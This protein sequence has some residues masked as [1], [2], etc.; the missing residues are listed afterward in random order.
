MDIDLNK[1][2]NDGVIKINCM[3]RKNKKTEKKQNFR[4]EF[5][6]LRRLLRSVALNFHVDKVEL[7]KSISSNS[8]QSIKLIDW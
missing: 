4:C 7:C 8:M 2:H 1:Y 6:N 5:E 3:P